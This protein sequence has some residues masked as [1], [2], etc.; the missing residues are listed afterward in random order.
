MTIYFDN[1]ATSFPK[2]PQVHE[3]VARALRQ[4]GS[5]GRGAHKMALQASIMQFESRERIAQF[6]GI[7][8]SS[9]LIFTP[10]C[11]ASINLVL[12]GLAD[13][14][15]L[16]AGAV[17]LVSAFEHNAVMRPLAALAAGHGLK[18]M[19]VPP[20]A[21]AGELVSVTALK[22]MLAEHRPV[23]CAFSRASN[24]TGRVLDIELLA[25]LFSSGGAGFGV[26]VLIDAAQSAGVIAEN[27]S[28]NSWIS[29]WAAAGHKSLYGPPGIG[30]LYVASGQFIDPPWRGGTGSSGADDF[31]MPENYPDRLE[32]GTAAVFL[33]CGLAAGVDYVDHLDKLGESVLASQARLGSYFLHALKQ[34]E[35]SKIELLGRDAGGFYLPTFALR[36]PGVSPDV[37]AHLLDDQ[38][39]V[40]VRPGLHCAR[41]AHDQLGTTEQG[42]LRVSFGLANTEAEIDVLCQALRGMLL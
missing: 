33:A 4:G 27:L 19:T 29:F 7:A 30:L 26:P 2:P 12:S 37:V 23:L 8:D 11:T 31:T 40:A 42:L 34:A 16:P 3:A 39:D 28:G 15:R 32:P 20:G 24:V 17:V 13:A 10:G 35:L 5:P 41:A 22:A 9:R 6:L 36:I 1:A 21:L 18:V 38:F 25:P 14:G